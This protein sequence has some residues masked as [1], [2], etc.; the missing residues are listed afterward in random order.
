[1]LKSLTVAAAGTSL[2]LAGCDSGVK[3]QAPAAPVRA[4]PA[5]TAAARNAVRS[6]VAA[7]ADCTPDK[8]LASDRMKMKDLGGAVGVV[9]GCSTGM[10]DVWSR[11][12]LARPG[13]APVAEPLL[14]FDNR[15][16]G[17][18]HAEPDLPNLTWSEEAGTVEASIR[19]QATNCGWDARWRWNGTRMA[20]VEM[21]TIG[22][23]AEQSTD[24]VVWPTSPAT[25]EPTPAPI[26]AA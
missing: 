25:P 24:A 22:C 7:D 3:T 26:P 19:A 12:Y 13:A 10:V 8:L 4:T 14:V 9:A 16:D 5:D 2:L 21:K 18:W 23:D 20:L 17:Q 11:L 15:G 1:M 6:L